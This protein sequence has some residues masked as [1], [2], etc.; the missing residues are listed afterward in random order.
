M[1]L[2]S[3][4]QEIKMTPYLVTLTLGSNFMAVS[5]ARGGS[6]TDGYL[7]LEDQLDSTYYF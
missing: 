6:D 2:G 7:N 1:A 4:V 3:F 5:A